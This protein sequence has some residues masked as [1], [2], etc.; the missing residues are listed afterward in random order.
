[1]TSII[2]QRA[3]V[4]APRTR[5]ELDALMLRR[6][7]LQGQLRTAEERRAALAAQASNMPPEQRGALTG[8]LA[9][10]DQRIERLEAQVLQLDQA[11]EMGLANPAVVGGAG[12]E[13]IDVPPTPGVPP[14]I[15]VPEV[16]TTVPTDPTGV[17]PEVI[18]AGTLVSLSMMALVAWVTWRRAM[19]RFART[20]GAS[21]GATADVARLQQSVDAMA[22]EVE[23]ISEGQRF[24][25]KVLNERAPALDVGVRQPSE[26]RQN[27]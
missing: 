8:R 11:I 4:I 13:A 7:E 19:S 21:L 22:I 24:L 10:L 14:V 15:H 17:H 3:G 1:M 9:T 18:V 16:F 6:S 20:H 5:P 26:Q 25:T 23:R 2:Q 27:V 12:G